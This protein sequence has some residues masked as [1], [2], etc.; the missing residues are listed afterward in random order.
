MIMFLSSRLL[1]GKQKPSQVRS[2]QLFITQSLCQREGPTS[3][4]TSLAPLLLPPTEGSLMVKP[5]LRHGTQP[6]HCS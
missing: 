2:Q 1:L 3:S 4:S 6:T 5:A